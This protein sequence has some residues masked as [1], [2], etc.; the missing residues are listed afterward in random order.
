MFRYSFLF[1]I[2]CFSCNQ[3]QEEKYY[4]INN[5]QNTFYS[6]P[7]KSDSL[8]KIVKKNYTHLSK[9][10]KIWFHTVV[11]D[12]MTNDLKK[13]DYINFILK[14][15]KPNEN[16]YLL[17][18]PVLYNNLCISYTNMQQ[19]EKA[20]KASL[21]AVE[22]S[23]F[24]R[25]K[26]SLKKSKLEFSYY[27]LAL[28]YRYSNNFI[29]YK[30]YLKKSLIAATSE[31]SK[32]YAYQ[33][34]G[35]YYVDKN[36]DSSYIYSKKA[37]DIFSKTSNAISP[38][39]CSINI[40]NSF[41]NKRKYNEALFY[42]EK[43]CQGLRKLNLK[44]FST[45]YTLLGNIYLKLNNNSKAIENFKIAQNNATTVEEN[46]LLYKGLRDYYKNV[47][48]SMMTLKSTD[49][50]EKYSSKYY[51]FTIAEKTK[52]LESNF[53]LK[54]KD[55][56]INQLKLEKKVE[57]E[58]NRYKS[59]LLFV[60]ILVSLIIIFTF[61]LYNKNSKLKEEN[62]KNLL[63]QKLFASQMSPH[64][65]FNALSAIQAEV[66]SNNVKEAN[67]YLTKFGKLLSNILINT[68]QENVSIASEYINIINYIDLQKIRY[69]N[70][71]YQ[72]DVYQGIDEDEDEIPP[73]LIQPLV[74]N[75]IEHGIKTLQNGVLKIK[76]KKYKDVLYCEI[77]D[78][79]L[80]LN[81]GSKSNAI[82]TGLIEKRLKFLEKKYN[83]KL[84]LEIK[85]NTEKA[86]VIS[87]ITIPYTTKFI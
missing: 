43:G 16:E 86:G 28:A 74:E 23:L 21:S 50:L 18:Y 46:Y 33:N 54:Q 17:N 61:Y 68:N 31:D 1:L 70:F 9:D 15:I 42:A 58:K 22:Y 44:I 77:I 32:A 11:I 4:S 66:L 60:I 5:L 59:V 38:L 80:G 64:F 24:I 48:N 36:N 27:N 56:S 81:S 40:A 84:D 19:Y 34:L 45:D 35:D 87:K 20:V 14:S 39:E 79:G 41:Y 3:R 62:N 69:K 52:E 71:D 29:L 47:N 37:Y 82:S 72:L 73:M 51:D 78:N 75:A 13:I 6:H 65:I 25:K 49:S 67:L 53:N 85:N 55:L 30:K 26:Y 63:E 57:T 83:K 2:L 7:E 12:T 8:L 10:D 76:V